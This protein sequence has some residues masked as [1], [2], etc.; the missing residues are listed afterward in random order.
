MT[1]YLKNENVDADSRHIILSFLTK[2]LRKVI[3]LPELTDAEK[4]ACQNTLSLMLSMCPAGEPEPLPT[5][6]WEHFALSGSEKIRLTIRGKGL[7]KIVRQQLQ[8]S[9]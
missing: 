3:G 9:S 8:H 6:R 2:Q 1:A 7:D 4:S 5:N